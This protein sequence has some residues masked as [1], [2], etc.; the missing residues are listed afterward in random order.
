MPVPG[1][2]KG[3]P[4]LHGKLD[5]SAH[6]CNSPYQLVSVLTAL[7]GFFYRH[8]IGEFS[9]TVRGKEAGN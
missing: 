1:V 6:S 3:R 8:E 4:A 9:S 7:F 5:G 2:V